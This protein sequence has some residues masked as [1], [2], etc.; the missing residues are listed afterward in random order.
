MQVRFYV[1]LGLGWAQWTSYGPCSQTCQGTQMRIRTCLTSN[2][3][4]LGNQTRPC[5]T[6][7]CPP[8]TPPSGGG[9]NPGGG[10]S[11]NPVGGGSG[12][13]SLGPGS[14]QITGNALPIGN[15]AGARSKYLFR[16]D[17]AMSFVIIA[18]KIIIYQDFHEFNFLFNL[19][20]VRKLNLLCMYL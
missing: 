9:G 13:V 3:L 8:P 10:G 18:Y 20:S 6:Q 7:P 1:V 5:N 19:R 16:F 15:S 11:G 2:C 4:G 14:T 17:K 12:N